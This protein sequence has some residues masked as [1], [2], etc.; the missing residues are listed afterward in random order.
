[1]Q[2]VKRV[3]RKVPICVDILCNKCGVSCLK[4][5]GKNHNLDSFECASIIASWGY[6]SHKDGARTNAHLCEDC[7]DELERTF[8]IPATSYDPDGI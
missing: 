4:H 7:L 5:K 8:V 2:R 3:S 1:M 6:E